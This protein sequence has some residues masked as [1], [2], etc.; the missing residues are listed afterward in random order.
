MACEDFPCCGHESG[1]CPDYDSSGRQLNMRCIC[2]ATLPLNNRSSL[3]DGCLSDEDYEDYED[4]DYEDEHD[5][6]R[7]DVEADADALSSAGWGTDED[8]GY[9][10]DD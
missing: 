2:G 1:C 9:Y 6:F 7:D 5:Q 4:E 10:G 3:C 8:Y